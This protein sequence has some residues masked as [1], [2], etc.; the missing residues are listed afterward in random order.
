MI[1]RCRSGSQCKDTFTTERGLN[2]HRKTCN[3]Y[4][5][6]EAAAFA[7]RKLVAEQKKMAVTNKRTKGKGK[8][9]ADITEF[10]SV[11]L[12]L[13]PIQPAFIINFV[14]WF[15][16]TSVGAIINRVVFDL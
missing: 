15:A 7:K 5:R 11:S 10:G 16:D 2:L 13:R 9:D 6:Y 1:Y 4:K 3:Y 12:P 14:A 8:E